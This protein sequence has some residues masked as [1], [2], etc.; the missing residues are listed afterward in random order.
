MA[1][2][3]ESSQSD[4]VSHLFGSFSDASN[5]EEIVR[6]FQQLC[7]KLDLDENQYDGFYAS[8]RQRLTEWRCQAV[9]KLLDERAALPVYKNQLVCKGMRVL[10][11]GAG[12]VGLRAAIEAALLGAKVDLVEKR[13][14]FS[15]NNV[16]HLWPFLLDDL[17]ALCAKKFYGKFAAGSIDHISK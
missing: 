14:S 15:R 16:L 8:M 3:D 2:S 9:W 17:K 10:V 13:I 12:P 6:C 11:V 1:H 4:S 5:L 7:K